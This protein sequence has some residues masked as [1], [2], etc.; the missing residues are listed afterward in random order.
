MT[1]RYIHTALGR[2]YVDISGAGEPILLLPSLLT[3]HTL[4]AAQIRHFGDRY[5]T[6]AV[7][8][9]G[10][11]SSEHLERQFS[12]EESARSYLQILD[13][14][15]FAR[16]HI[17][18][19]S[20]GAMIG[21]TLAASYPDRVA[22]AILI[23]G[24]ASPAPAW[25]R[26]KLALSAQLSRRLGRMAFPRILVVPRFLGATTRRTRP[27]LVDD[28][29]TILARN[30][31]RSASLAVESIVVNRPDQ[32]ALFTRIQ[33]PVLIITGDEDISFPVP[34]VRRMAR[35]IPGSEFAVL[36]HVGHLAAYEAPDVVNRLIDD[37]LSRHPSA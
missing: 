14:L 29:L 21:G 36:D 18:G 16:A 15:G 5:T 11:G 34:E 25:D 23:N 28:F 33:S 9:P 13:E 19:N 7:D 20:W 2:I 6:I 30:N 3:D 8:P 10:Q 22:C 12:F 26:R 24:T 37:F 17:V 4:F 31:P 1:G 35:A 32:H 27:E